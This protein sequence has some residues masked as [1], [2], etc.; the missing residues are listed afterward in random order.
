MGTGTCKC[1]ETTCRFESTHEV[2]TLAFNTLIII[3]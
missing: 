2:F 3:D 1:F